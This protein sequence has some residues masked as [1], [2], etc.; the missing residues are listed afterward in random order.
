MA[1][2]KGF[3]SPP[4][5]ASAALI[6]LGVALG[7][8]FSFLLYYFFY[9]FRET[10]RTLTG[11]FTHTLLVELTPQENFYYNLFYGS[12]AAVLGFY[13]FAHFVLSG[14][15]DRKN[16]RRRVR[17]RQ[18][19][20]DLSFVGWTFFNGF[21]RFTSLLGI[22]F[23]TLPLQFD[24]N[25]LI[26]FPLLLILIPVVL[27]LN[28]WTLIVKHFGRKAYRWFLYTTGY[29]LVLSLIYANVSPIDYQR[30]NQ[31]MRVYGGEWTHG[32]TV[33]QSESQEVF[34]NQTVV[35]L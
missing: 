11:Y 24:L 5:A 32:I 1:L 22:W 14:S 28:A 19:L 34:S 30:I 26:E 12:I 29:L 23:L 17:Q 25:F 13:V 9:Y 3:L 4:V 27:Y 6:Q 33:P 8:V 20:N 10:I 21:A 18:I 2:S 15:V 7:T 16:G 31:E 35:G